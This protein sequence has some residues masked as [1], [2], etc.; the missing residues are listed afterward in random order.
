MGKQE[1]STVAGYAFRYGVDRLRI[2]HYE[3]S[4]WDKTQGSAPEDWRPKSLTKKKI[5]IAG[6]SVEYEYLKNGSNWE[7]DRY[8]VYVPA[9]DGKAGSIEISARSQSVGDIVQAQLYHYDHLGSISAVTGYGQATSYLDDT[10]SKD[11]VYSYDAW[12]ERRDPLDW[13]GKPVS[14]SK[15]G[16]DDLLPRGFTGHEMLDDLGLVHMNG[17]IYDPLL[18]RFLSADVLVDGV[19]TVQGYNR[20][21][22]V[23]NNPLH[24][25]DP[26]GY[27]ASG[28]VLHGG[29]SGANSGQWDETDRINYNDVQTEKGNT[30]DPLWMPGD[31]PRKRPK[32]KIEKA[33]ERNR[34]LPILSSGSDG[35]DSS[36]ASK[37]LAEAA[38]A[39]AKVKKARSP[40]EQVEGAEIV[41][42]EKETI[43][44]K[45]VTY[46]NKSGWKDGKLVRDRHGTRTIT[47]EFEVQHL[48][49]DGVPSVELLSMKIRGA[50]IGS[51]V[52]FSLPAGPMSAR[53]G[54]GGRVDIRGLD[55]SVPILNGSGGLSGMGLRLDYQISK[56]TY[57]VGSFSVN[58][59]AAY[60]ST[61]LS[62]RAVVAGSLAVVPNGLPGQ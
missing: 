3:F 43:T 36:E 48:T 37:D 2:A 9:P 60:T 58:G 55:V 5:Y 23:K 51:Q 20:Y 46:K 62:T 6:G 8:R 39:E 10:T 49:V 11:S 53:V 16:S 44:H 15:G 32:T 54:F 38:A 52:G 25:T 45:Y 26:S 56:S 59:S 12:G 30:V 35:E 18:G 61:D 19:T 21:S 1:G 50:N 4:D 7:I 40:Q 24:Y 57:I 42:G 17:R 13:H 47:A 33:K 41:Y 31:D 29:Y 34:G 14:T 27:S 22:Y 28:R